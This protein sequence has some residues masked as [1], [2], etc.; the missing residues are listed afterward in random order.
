[1]K[2]ESILAH[3]A[4]GELLLSSATHEGG[5]VEGVKKTS[6]GRYEN[7]GGPTVSGF[8]EEIADAPGDSDRGGGSGAEEVGADI[9][10]SGPEEAYS[11]GS[12][13]RGSPHPGEPLF[14]EAKRE[15]G[16]GH[17]TEAAGLYRQVIEIDP[18][19]VRAHNNLAVLV[20]QMGDHDVAL[21]HLQAALELDPENAEVLANLGAVLA[22]HGS[23]DQAESHL[24][25]ASRLDPTSLDVRAN[26][27]LIYYRRGLY[28]QADQEFRWVCEQDSSHALAHFYRGEALNQLGR[29]DEALEVLSQASRL[30]PERPRTYYLMGI[31]YDKKNLCQEAAEMYRKAR[32]LSDQ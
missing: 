19:H 32:E 15:A 6:V 20:D 10:G 29:I 3:S 9:S 21:E 23:Y 11:P 2:E 24:R 8:E 26:M 14:E 30:Q 13:H 22:A 7:S 12:L 5:L 16:V 25:R 18:T 17:L 28:G 4:Q 31:I 1:M 27:G